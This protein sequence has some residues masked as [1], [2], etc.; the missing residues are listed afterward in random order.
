MLQMQVDAPK[1]RASTRARVEVAEQERARQEAAQQEMVRKKH[2]SIQKTR[3]LKPA[4]LRA[5][6]VTAGR[7]QRFQGSLWHVSYATQ[8]GAH[9]LATS[10]KHAT[11]AAAVSVQHT[12]RFWR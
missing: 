8:D 12:G 9:V 4:V 2:I 1:L 10:Y 6:W 3:D 5:A 11:R 7:W